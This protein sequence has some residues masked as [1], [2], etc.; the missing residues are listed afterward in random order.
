M[1]DPILSISFSMHSN[2]GVYALLLGSG[3]SR[4][5]NIPTGWEITLDLIRKLAHLK[6]EI[7]E[8]DPVKWYQDKF[9]EEASYS[10]LLN[11][12]AKTPSERSK[13]LKTYF[14]PTEEE[15]QQNIKTP[16]IAHRAI[17]NLVREGYVRVIITTNFD[18]LIET[19]LEDVGIRPIVI[20]TSDAA[21]GATPIVHTP[22]RL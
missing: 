19:A 2:K 1:I 8:P 22:V 18:R 14:E 11:Q 4:S 17:A 10:K 16:T 9:S 7:C 21:N 3:I 5:A 13:L 6:K 20:S 15:R 12:V